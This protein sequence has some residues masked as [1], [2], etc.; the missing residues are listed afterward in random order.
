MAAFRV[1]FRENLAEKRCD[2]FGHFS[3]YFNEINNEIS[4]LNLTQDQAKIIYKTSDEFC[5]ASFEL[6]Q[7]LCSENIMQSLKRIEKAGNYVRGEIKKLSTV[8]VRNLLYETS[9]NYVAPVFNRR[10]CI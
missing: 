2:P 9:T 4:Q 1:D 7:K 8:D 6:V 10:E 5:G 3:V